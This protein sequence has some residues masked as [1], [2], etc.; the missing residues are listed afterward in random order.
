MSAFP[1]AHP[2]RPASHASRDADGYAHMHA[3]AITR[4]PA[5]TCPDA[6]GMPLCP[7]ARR[8]HQP[9]CLRIFPNTCR[10]CL[11]TNTE[12]ERRGDG[13]APTHSYTYE[14]GK[15]SVP[16]AKTWVLGPGTQR[17]TSNDI[18]H[19]A[20]PRPRSTATPRGHAISQ[21]KAGLG[22]MQ[23]HGKQGRTKRHCPSW[24]WRD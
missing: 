18:S 9:A 7:R 16:M 6:G 10:H 12:T 20:M 22:N 15:V 4:M 24:L 11:F 19:R 14:L 17:R 8:S 21:G 13:H 5:H 23:Q 3:H 1:H 2:C